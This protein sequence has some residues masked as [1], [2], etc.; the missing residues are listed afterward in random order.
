MKWWGFHG[1]T[2]PSPALAWPVSLHRSGLPVL[3]PLLQ[4]PRPHSSPPDGP[5]TAPGP[6]LPAEAFQ[7]P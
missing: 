1:L 2:L 3:K 4:P 7:E 5:C 6:G